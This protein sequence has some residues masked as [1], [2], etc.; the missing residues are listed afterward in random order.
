MQVHCDPY[1]AGPWSDHPKVIAKSDKVSSGKVKAVSFSREVCE[2]LRKNWVQRS[3][4][5]WRSF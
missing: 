1:S 3:F 4:L 5:E 2:Q